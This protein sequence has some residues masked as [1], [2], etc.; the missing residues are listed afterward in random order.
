[1]ICVTPSA[2]MTA[3]GTCWSGDTATVLVENTF[4][5]FLNEGALEGVGRQNVEDRLRWTGETRAQR[6]DNER[7]VDQDGMLK[8]GVE[9]LIVGQ[10][11]IAEAE[12]HIGRAFLPDRPA[13]RKA[14]IG[15]HAE[16]LGAAR[17]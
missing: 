6:R 12:F 3:A 7:P 1:M 13:D 11:G 16:K 2:A 8:H 15:D 10:R 5:V 17:R 4:A 14:G 9:Q